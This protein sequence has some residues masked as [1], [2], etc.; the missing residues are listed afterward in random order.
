M[1]TSSTINYT[2]ESRKTNYLVTQTSSF[3]TWIS[4]VVKMCLSVR[5]QTNCSKL[6]FIK[7]DL[8][9][10]CCQSCWRFVIKWG[11]NA[12]CKFC[13]WGFDGFCLCILWSIMRNVLFPQHQPR[14]DYWRDLWGSCLRVQHVKEMS[15]WTS[16][17]GI[18]LEPGD[19]W[20]IQLRFEQTAFSNWSLILSP[21]FPNVSVSSHFIP[22]LAAA[23]TF[24]DWSNLEYIY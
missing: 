24:I 8:V 9:S 4:H 7:L 1:H 2:L 22:T 14:I 16:S 17:G 11:N 23:P 15:V 19:R 10:L 6:I 3:Y 20:V 12:S 18:S 13:L 5:F 21:R